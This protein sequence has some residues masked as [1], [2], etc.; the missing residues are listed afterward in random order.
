MI[1]DYKDAFVDCV[2]RYIQAEDVRRHIDDAFH[3]SHETFNNEMT[4]ICNDLLIHIKELSHTD[5][6]VE[7][8]NSLQELLV[9]LEHK[10]EINPTIFISS[11]ICS[12]LLS[13]FQMIPIG[14]EDMILRLILILSSNF[15]ISEAFYQLKSDSMNIINILDEY[16]SETKDKLQAQ[17]ILYIYSNFIPSLCKEDPYNILFLPFDKIEK[18]D[19]PQTYSEFLK[20]C[21]RCNKESTFS[22]TLVE[23]ATKLFKHVYPESGIFQWIIF[24]ISQNDINSVCYILEDNFNEEEGTLFYQIMLN[25]D[26]KSSNIAHPLLMFAYNV[27]EHSCEPFFEFITSEEDFH[28]KS[29]IREYIMNDNVDTKRHILR[30]LVALFKIRK[31]P[32]VQYPPDV[33]NEIVPELIERMDDIDYQSLS[34]MIRIFSYMICE[35][36]GIVIQY[37]IDERYFYQMSRIVHDCPDIILHQIYC[38]SKFAAQENQTQ[39]LL[40]FITD[41]NLFDEIYQIEIINEELKQELYDKISVINQILGVESEG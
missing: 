9:M 6:M 21:A 8:G 24:Y 11:G 1:L 17:T 4:T 2:D 31:H 40:S 39:T 36:Q 37:L 3:P 28:P 7:I 22:V 27:L 18:I 38:I 20:E 13:L 35:Y 26:M 29:L 5:D 19:I 32:F 12:Y 23:K 10:E 34:Y 16:I 41:Y 25:N 33:V 14:F 15:D 30:L